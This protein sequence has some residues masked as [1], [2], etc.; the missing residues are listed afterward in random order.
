MQLEFVPLLQIQRDLYRLPRGQERFQTYLK[1]MVAP[2]GQTLLLPPLAPMVAHPYTYAKL[3]YDPARDLAPVS[4]VA[5]TPIIL[6]VHPSLPVKT[7]GDLVRLAKARP[8]ELHFASS[9]NGA[10]SHLSGEMLRERAGIELE[11]L[12]GED[13]ARLTF[14]AVRRWFGWSSGRLLVLDI[15]GGSLEVAA[16]GDEYPDVAFSLPLLCWRNTA[17]SSAP[18]VYG[19]RQLSHTRRSSR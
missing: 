12:A 13:E 6:V 2:D 10:T 3:N 1:A 15:G 8:G 17:S 11:V 5:S 14:L 16:G 7:V 19:S 4:L 18:G 9:G